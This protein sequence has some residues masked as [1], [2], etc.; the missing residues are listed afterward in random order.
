M[1]PQAAGGAGSWR[2]FLDYLD[3]TGGS[4]TAD[5]LF[6]TYVASSGRSRLLDVAH[7]A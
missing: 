3:E 1:N 6:E 4:K 7:S 2:R 5:Q